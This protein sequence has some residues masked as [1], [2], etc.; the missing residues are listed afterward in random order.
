MKKHLESGTIDSE[1]E[2]L[3]LLLLM[4]KQWMV[5]TNLTFK[6]FISCSI[7]YFVLCVQKFLIMITVRYID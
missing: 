4:P 7:H 6:I 3:T 1:L 2:M 5:I